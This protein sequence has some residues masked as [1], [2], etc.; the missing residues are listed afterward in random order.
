MITGLIVGIVIVWAGL[1][2]IGV[3]AILRYGKGARDGD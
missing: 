1:V 2:G 3:W